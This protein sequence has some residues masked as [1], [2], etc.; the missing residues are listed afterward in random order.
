[1]PLVAKTALTAVMIAAQMAA[2]TRLDLPLLLGAIV[3]EDPEMK[4]PTGTGSPD[5]S[6]TW[7]TA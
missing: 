6:S 7:G 5:S 3:N 2:L 4:T 1:V